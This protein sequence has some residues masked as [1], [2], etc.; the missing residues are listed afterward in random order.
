MKRGGVVLGDGLANLLVRQLFHLPDNLDF[1]FD[2]GLAL[3]AAG[4]RAKAQNGETDCGVDAICYRL[5]I[6]GRFVLD[7]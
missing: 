3:E 1:V 6:A 7:S 5:E 2:V 4:H